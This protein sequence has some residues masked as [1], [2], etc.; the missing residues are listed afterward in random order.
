M[1]RPNALAVIVIL[2][3]LSLPLAGAG[4]ASA[5]AE[6]SE[7]AEI[8]V[9][10]DDSYP[11]YAFRDQDGKLVGILP[12]QWEA[13]SEATG[14][15]VRFIGLPWAEAQRRVT[16][17]EIDVLE[18]VFKTRERELIYDFTPPYAQI[19][20]PVFIHSSISGIR[21]IADLRGFRVAAKKGDAAVGQLKEH[22][23]WYIEEYPDYASIVEAA[24]RL[25]VRIFCVDRPPALYYLY[26][27]GI[28]HDF[29][30]AFYLKSG[31]FRRAA[32]KGREDLLAQVEKGFAA[33]PASTYERIDSAW[34]GAPLASRVNLRVGGIVVGSLAAI[35]LALTGIA[36]ILR[37]R[38]A[39]ATSELRSKI[40]ELEK[41]EDK[42]RAIIAA[43]PDLCFV[44]DREGRY[45]DYSA[46]EP[47]MLA[48][49]PEAFIGKTQR[50]LDFPPQV[51]E[52]FETA[53]ARVI[54]SARM[55]VIQYDL[56][57]AGQTKS[58]E[59]RIVPL[60]DDQVLA[61]ARDMTE[62]KRQAQMLADSLAEK[63][64]LLKEVHHRVKNNMQLISSLL[65]LE[66]KSFRDEEDSRRLV[67]A[68]QRIH[69]IAR[70]HE[71]A[72]GS[73]DLASIGLVEYLEALARGLS[74]DRRAK[75]IEVRGPRGLRIPV[76]EAVL[77][78]LIANELMTNA[79]KYGLGPQGRS[80]IVASISE[81][82]GDLRFSVEDDGPGLP[83]GV[84]PKTSPSMGFLLIRSLTAQLDGRASFSGPPGLRVEIE[85]H[86]DGIDSAKPGDSSSE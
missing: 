85:C 24:R 16:A 3:S 28:D 56:E 26:K 41:S 64:V 18:T 61:I 86:I 32:L 71:M 9:A 79:I 50:E 67:E 19:D 8:S 72:Y 69:S 1:A 59:C 83:A 13:W 25:E 65:A 82:G 77:L 34:L 53:I 17:G 55:E 51:T 11:P 74:M 36:W 70:L 21:S 5:G 81:S 46:P 60:A 62:Q 2:A 66:S 38:V 42:N 14:I 15:G 75:A 23:I 39:A 20:V 78:G 33:I 54:G 7:K 37:R 84:D 47:S 68:Q 49:P 52:Y 76:S 80:L 57:M 35:V 29:R 48:F 73:P 63:E 22:G 40:E 58:F 45:L 6:A 30:I 27:N 43:L 44:I 31:A 12:D 4:S 10:C